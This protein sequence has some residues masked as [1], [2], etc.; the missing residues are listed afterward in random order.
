MKNKTRLKRQYDKCLKCSIELL[1]QLELL[2][3]TATEI[4]GEEIVA[5]ICSGN[6][7]EFRTTDANGTTNTDC[8]IQ[9]EDL[10]EL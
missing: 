7:I 8:C 9:L 1:S 2:S 5:E 4:Y 6:E 3:I 10:L